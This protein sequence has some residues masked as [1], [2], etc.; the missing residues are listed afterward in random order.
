MEKPTV[1]WYKLYKKSTVWRRDVVA[2][3]DAGNFPLAPLALL[4]L[5]PFICS[6]ILLKTSE[7]RSQSGIEGPKSWIFHAHKKS[8]LALDMV[9]QTVQAIHCMVVQ[10]VQE[11]TGVLST[12]ET[13]YNF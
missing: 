11:R 10:T 9:V 3:Q 12:L 8:R 5:R 2:H 4:I 1:W 7:E 13:V 6:L